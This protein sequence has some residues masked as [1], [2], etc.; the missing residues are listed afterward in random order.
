MSDGLGYDEQ[1]VTMERGFVTVD[2]Y[3]R[4]SVPGVYAVG[5]LTPG[6]QLA[7]VG[8]GEGILVAEQIAGLPVVPIDYAGVPRITYSYPEVASVGLTEADAAAK[9]GAD[10]IKTVTYDLAG[11]GRSAILKTQ[12][13]GQAGRRSRTGR[14]S[15]STSSATA[16]AS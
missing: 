5:D 6:P 3:C 7:H 16:S 13:R 10:A 15:A 11:N 8:F 4:T 2:E 12:G 9:Y 14:C 1:G